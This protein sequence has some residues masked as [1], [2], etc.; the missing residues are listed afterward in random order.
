MP[1]AIDP[2]TFITSALAPVVAL[3]ACAILASNAQSQYSLLIDRLRDLNDERRGYQDSQPLTAI[4]ADRLK[5]LEH[6]I[7]VFYRRALLLRNAM[8]LLFC[9]MMAILL[10]SFLIVSRA[11]FRWEV[12]SVAAKWSFFGGLVC[13]FLAV[14]SMLIEVFLT[15]RVVRYELGLFD[16]AA[17]RAAEREFREY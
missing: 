16:P 10:T 17:R 11:T 1:A 15:S 12:L 7:P 8:F 3:S 2:L 9:A 13:V 6:Q 4:Q 14:T 5:S